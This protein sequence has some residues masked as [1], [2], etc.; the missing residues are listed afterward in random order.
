M[1]AREAILRAVPAFVATPQRD[2]YALRLRLEGDGVPSQLAMEVVEFMP[3]AVARA[4]LAGM[5]IRFSDEYVRQ[6]SQGRVIGRKR[7][8]DEP[9]FREATEMADEIVRMGQEAFMAVAGWSVEYRHVRAALNAGAA[10][11]DLGY[12]PPVVTAVNE[13][14]RE[15]DDT[16]GGVQERDRKWWEF[17][18][19]RPGG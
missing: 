12:E 14:T 7:L 2:T 16:S 9:V 5:G 19:A 15:F 8:H 10:A 1:T 11:G 6:T 17:W 13:D 3:L 18:R 4:L